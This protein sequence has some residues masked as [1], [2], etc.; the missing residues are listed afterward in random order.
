MN[1][2]MNRW[3]QVRGMIKDVIKTESD[4]GG[5]KLM[6]MDKSCSVIL[7]NGFGD[8]TTRIRN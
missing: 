3:Y 7:C 1:E 2:L 6:S 8:G 4:V 5:V